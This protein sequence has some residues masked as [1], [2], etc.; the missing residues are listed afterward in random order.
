[1]QYL[2]VLY[3]GHSNACRTNNLVKCPDSYNKLNDIVAFWLAS[4]LCWTENK[5]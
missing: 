2:K 3:L 5:L 4:L 1:M